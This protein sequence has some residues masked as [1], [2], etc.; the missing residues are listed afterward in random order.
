MNGRIVGGVPAH[1]PSQS[2]N[3]DCDSDSW[4]AGNLPIDN[5]DLEEAN[6]AAMASIFADF[7]EGQK[8]GSGN[9]LA[10]SFNP[11]APA[12]DPHRLREFYYFTNPGSILPGLRYCLFHENGPKLPRSE[13]TAWTDIYVAFW[14][15]VGELIQ[16]DESPAKGSWVKTFDAWKELAN[17]FI[18]GYSNGGLQAWTLPCL[19]VV[20]KYLRVFAMRADAEI[21]AQGSGAYDFQ[22]D[23]A[24]EFEKSAK[25]EDTARTINRMFIL[26]LSDRYVVTGIVGWFA[27]SVSGHLLRILVNGVFIT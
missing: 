25:L 15:A 8:T 27:D 23:F 17:V 21:Q 26:C 3:Q 14:T 18:R 5:L 4:L 6:F 22:D 13:Q 10:S 7:K 12:D 19:Y 9:R 20:G 16:F 11:V 2:P 1:L 24:S